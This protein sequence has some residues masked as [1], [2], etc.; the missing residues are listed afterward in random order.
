[1]PDLK[2]SKRETLFWLKDAH[3]LDHVH[4]VLHELSKLAQA[5]RRE[6]LWV[7]ESAEL[8]TRLKALPNENFIKEIREA[9]VSHPT[10]IADYCGVWH[11]H[12][13]AS[14]ILNCLLREEVSIDDLDKGRN[15][16][17]EISVGEVRLDERK[18][19][20]RIA[21][22]SGTVDDWIVHL[23]ITKANNKHD[24]TFFIKLGSALARKQRP[25]EMDCERI[26]IVPRFLVE[27]WCGVYD[28][29]GMWLDQ[30]AEANVG[31]WRGNKVF[32]WEQAPNCLL[33]PPLCF[34]ASSALAT[35]CALELGKKQSDK[36]TSATAVRKWVSRLRLE[37]ACT[38]K[39]REV[40][41]A[42][43]G[44]YFVT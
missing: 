39:I 4:I 22:V 18:F 34:F 3:L 21:K 23:A 38:P 32:V 30:L 8:L 27:N 10:Q 40:K 29:Y 9:I 2:H 19:A 44:I 15:E 7:K 16:R 31:H 33:M 20:L 17:G 5:E 25:P 36:D 6:F 1:M 28:H 26:G 43:D 13:T 11:S 12:K 37:A 35:F 24:T 42:A 14:I 41:V